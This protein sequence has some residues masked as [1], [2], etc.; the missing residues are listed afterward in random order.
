MRQLRTRKV[1]KKRRKLGEVEAEV[2]QADEEEAD[3][4]EAEVAEEEEEEEEE[5]T[6]EDIEEALLAEGGIIV[7]RV[8]IAD[9]YLYYM[10]I[11]LLDSASPVALQ[12]CCLVLV[13]LSPSLLRL[14]LALRLRLLLDLQSRLLPGL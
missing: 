4:A 5:E 6:A 14:L 12:A 10:L 9:E 2:D 7:R 8:M 1:W 3:N 11:C 13:C